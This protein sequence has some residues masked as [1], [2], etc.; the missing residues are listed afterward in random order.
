MAGKKR[1]IRDKYDDPEITRQLRALRTRDQ[2][3]IFLNGSLEPWNSYEK[4]ELLKIENSPTKSVWQFLQYFQARFHWPD[5]PLG[6]SDGPRNPDKVFGWLSSLKLMGM[7]NFN[8]YCI[9]KVNYRFYMGFKE[10]QGSTDRQFPNWF[11]ILKMCLVL[12]QFPPRLAGPGRD[13][14]N[15]PRTEPK[16]SRSVCNR[17]LLVRGSL[18]SSFQI[19]VEE[20]VATMKVFKKNQF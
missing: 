16:P 2:M 18:I 11:D 6:S 20:F 12:V 4:E 19:R 9:Q 17:P 7:G 8:G 14:P 13:F 1:S 3:L 5:G 15:F 10:F